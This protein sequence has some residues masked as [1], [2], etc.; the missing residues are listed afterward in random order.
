MSNFRIE[1]R[2][3]KGTLTNYLHNI[4]NYATWE[5]DRIGGCG[6]GRFRIR[7]TFDGAVAGS[8]V[9]DSEIRVYIPN[10]AG[11]VQLWYSGFIDKV[12]P[13]LSSNEYIDLLCLK[14]Y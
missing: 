13:N 11:T 6:E 7:D 9:E 1:L 8:L 2:N 3:D 4:C 10:A 5:W 14:T 12:S